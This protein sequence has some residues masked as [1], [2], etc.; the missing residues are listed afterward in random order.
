MSRL[1]IPTLGSALVLATPTSITIGRVS[2]LD[3]LHFRTVKLGPPCFKLAD[4]RV[5]PKRYRLVWTIH[6]ESST[7]LLPSRLVLH[8]SRPR[9]A[10][11]V[12]WKSRAARSYFSM[13]PTFRVSF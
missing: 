8:A 1:N 9:H 11:L 13:I 3:K 5:D 10:E 12:K 6:V 2:D 7:S 4:A